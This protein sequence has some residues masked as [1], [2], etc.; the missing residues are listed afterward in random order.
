[1]WRNALFATASILLASFLGLMSQ[2][3]CLLPYKRVIADRYLVLAAIYTALFS[4]NLFALFFVL[5]RFLML[6]DTGRKLEHVEKQE[7]WV[8][9]E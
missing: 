8:K 7:H 5:T 1:V 2:L 3:D 9:E 6:K 4:I